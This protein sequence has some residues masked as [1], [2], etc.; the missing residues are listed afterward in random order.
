MPTTVLTG[1]ICDNTCLG[2]SPGDD[3]PDYLGLFGPPF[4]NLMSRPFELDTSATGYTL[5]INGHSLSFGFGD[6]HFS[7]SFTDPLLASFAP[8]SFLF[9]ATGTNPFGIAVAETEFGC[10]FPEPFTPGVPEPTTWALMLLGFGLLAGLRRF[11]TSN[12]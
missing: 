3:T 5:T 6:P 1:N 2:F 11:R 8:G 4:G 9:T 10:P 7:I 12:P